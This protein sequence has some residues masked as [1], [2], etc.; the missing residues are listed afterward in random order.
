[1][2]RVGDERR[3]APIADVADGGLDR[4][5]D[6]RRIARVRAARLGTNSRVDRHDRKRVREDGGRSIRRVD[7]PDRY[8]PVE[9][10]SQR[11]EPIG[12]VDQVEG[13]EVVAKVEPSLEG[14]LTADA[15]RLAHRQG[16]RQRHRLTP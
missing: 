4:A 11:R 8:R 16:E 13:R 14:D 7:R 12:I 15:G 3:G 10:P 1:M 9:P 5:E 6:R 2:D